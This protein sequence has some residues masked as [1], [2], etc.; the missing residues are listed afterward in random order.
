MEF[1]RP[2]PPFLA[3]RHRQ[4]RAALPQVDRA[5]LAELAVGGQHPQAMIIACCDSRVMA[6]EMFAAA[7]GEF[8]VHR[9]IANLVPPF[10]P[11]GRQHGTSATIEFAVTTLRVAHL[12]VMGHYG[13]GGVKGCHDMLTGR[14]PELTETTSFMGSWLRVLAPGFEAV[15]EL[16]LAPEARLAALEKQGVLI[17]L[18]NLMTFPF[19]S[20][21][22]RAGTLQIHG[23]WKDIRDGALEVYDAEA[24]TFLRV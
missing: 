6:S 1:A 2:L 19:V 16:D 4:W 8:F 5:R 18:Q 23:A 10:Q 7:A 11:D 15:R 20:A 13:C 22:V 24:G 21:A 12:I 14:A 3:E 17:S 9:N